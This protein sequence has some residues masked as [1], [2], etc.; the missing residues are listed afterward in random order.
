MC[1][2]FVFAHFWA[3]EYYDRHVEDAERGEKMAGGM[4]VRRRHLIIQLRRMRR[5]AGLSQDE[6][7]KA[8]GWSRAKLQRLEAGEFQRLKA[9]DV[10]ALCQ[11]Y[12]ADKAE[13]EELVQIARDSRKNLPWWYQYKDV[14]PGAFIGMEAEAT[15]IQDFSIG[16]I[17]GLFQTQD[18]ITALFERAVGVPKQEVPKRLEIRL[19]RQRSVLDRER[20]PTIMAVIDESAIRREVGGEEVM[21]GQIRHLLDLSE[22]PNVEVQ[23]LPFKA[24]AHAGTSIPFVLFGFDGGGAAGSLVYLETRKDGFYLE[25]EEEV[26]DYRLVFSRMQGTAMSVED[27]AALLRTVL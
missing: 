22:R 16:L 15:L 25:E 26:T 17:P 4:P 18:Y 20:P 8:L 12:E 2:K 19:E 6:V 9:G 10:M 24:G 14:L 27:S 11:L 23:I 5:D 7:W 3:W 1:I 21:K 13:A